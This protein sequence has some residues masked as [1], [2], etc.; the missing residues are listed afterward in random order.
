[1]PRRSPTARPSTMPGSIAMIGSVPMSSM[2]ATMHCGLAAHE[3]DCDRAIERPGQL[4]AG[5]G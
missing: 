1:M 2:I 4:V 3:N 5:A